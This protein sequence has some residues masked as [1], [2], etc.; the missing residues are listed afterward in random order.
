MIAWL[1]GVFVEDAQISA[2]DR[3]FLL[4][5]GAFE[6]VYVERGRCA[7]LTEHIARLKSGLET[8]RITPPDFQ[9]IGAV[10]A[11]LASRSGIAGRAAMRLTVSRG[12][13]ERGLRFSGGAP[14]VLATITALASETP[15]TLRAVVSTR[16]RFGASSTACFKAIGGYLES[17]LAHNEALEAGADEALMLNEHGRLACAAAANVFIESKQ[18]IATPPVEEGALPG[19]IR[20]LI[21]CRSA[22]A[23][24]P[25]EE[26]PIETGEL[27][28]ASIYLTNSLIGVRRVILAGGA[29]PPPD[30]GGLP[31]LQSWYFKRLEEELARTSP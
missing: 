17:L 3:G 21:L 26:R 4:G 30:R 22:E 18:G 7:F 8:L 13:G 23:G 25:V 10:A 19:I 31:V 14:T 12:A 9:D 20:G 16:R 27:H 15:D 1:N 29:A 2:G 6:T 5:D 28:G 11:A 24:A